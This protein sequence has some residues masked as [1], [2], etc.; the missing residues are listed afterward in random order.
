MNGNYAFQPETVEALA[1]AFRKSWS[2]ISNDPCCASENPKVLQRRLVQ[3]LTQLA[4]EGEE[5]PVRL[6]NGAIGRMRHD[7]SLEAAFHAH[8]KERLGDPWRQ[9]PSKFRPKSDLDG[10]RDV[11]G[12]DTKKLAE[13]PA[14]VAP[15]E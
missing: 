12:P 7:D 5:D 4:A 9:V 15:T 2:F 14:T 10:R 13:D 6:A 11:H 1:T 3:C 8:R